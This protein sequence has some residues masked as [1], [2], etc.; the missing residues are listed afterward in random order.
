[1][2]LVGR[3]VDYVEFMAVRK[4]PMKERPRF[5]RDGTAVSADD[6]DAEDP[7]VSRVLAT[8]RQQVLTDRALYD[9]VK[10]HTSAAR[11]QY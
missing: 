5:S 9:K 8:I 3:E 6:M 10:P 7:D 2:L 4:I 11:L 1:M